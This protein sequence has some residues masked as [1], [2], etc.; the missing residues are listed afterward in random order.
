MA[1]GWLCWKVPHPLPAGR[2]LEPREASRV[3]HHQVRRDPG[4]L[5]LPLPPA[6]AFPQPQGGSPAPLGPSHHPRAECHHPPVPCPQVSN[7]PLLSLRS[8][9]NGRILGCGTRLG[10][11]SL[12]EI[13]PGL[14]TM[15][16][17]EKTLT[18]TVCARSHPSP[19]LCPQP[20]C[21]PRHST[22][23][24]VPPTP[25]SPASPPD[26]RAGGEAG[27]GPAGQTSGAAAAGAGPGTGPARGA[28][29]SPGGVR[30][31]QRRILLHHQGGEAE[32]GPGRP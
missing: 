6:G 17:N 2:V 11:V 4:H 16:K 21:V 13:S 9:D 15:R 18:S 23:S 3:L 10:V 26:V 31:G 19:T 29:G 25:L 14:C 8:Q 27:E 32:E 28:G 30:E 1:E 5:G 20:C 22:G 24:P 12:L 7:D